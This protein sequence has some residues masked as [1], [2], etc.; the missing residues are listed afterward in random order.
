M[1][2]SIISDKKSYYFLGFLFVFVFW[3]L[4]DF[5]FKNNYIVPGVGKTIEAFFDLF[6]EGNTYIILGFTITRLLIVVFCCLILGVILAVLSYLSYRFKAFL[7]PVI[8]LIKTLPI[9]VVIILLLIMFTREHAPMI[10]VG[11]VVFPLI[12]TA[13][14]SG[15]ENIDSFI[16]DEVKMLSNNNIQI[17]KSI[18]LPLTFPYILTSII[19]SFGLGLKVLVMAEYL[20]QPKYS[21]GNEIVF[22]QDV[23]VSMEYVYAWSMILILFVLIFEFLISYTTKKLVQ[24]WASFFASRKRKKFILSC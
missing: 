17:V 16:I 10:V 8:T 13:T 3:I 23:A 19:Q 9:A 24:N 11:V 6:G 7:K 20:S 2:R 15:L 5:S 18:Y 14:L 1:I 4:L 21:I 12:Y 22:Y